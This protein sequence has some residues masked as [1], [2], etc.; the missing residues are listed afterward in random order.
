MQARV[1]DPARR[2]YRWQA[3]PVQALAFAVADGRHVDGDDHRPVAR[4]AGAL[5]QAAD[6]LAIAPRIQLE[7]MRHASRSR[8]LLDRVSAG[9]GED[10]SGAR[11][12]GAASDGDVAL[13]VREAVEA[14]R[15]HEHREGERL[16][17]ELGR[18]V[19]VGVAGEHALAQPPVPE[20][21]AI[22][23]ERDPVVGG[24]VDVGPDHQ[25]N[26]AARGPAVALD[27]DRRLAAAELELDR[28]H[29]SRQP[30]CDWSRLEQ[31]GRDLDARLPVARA[32]VLVD[33]DLH[34]ILPGVTGDSAR[35]RARPLAGHLLDVPRGPA[36]RRRGDTVVE[37]R[38]R[39]CFR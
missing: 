27:A 32:D 7:P 11:V 38:T 36:R 16:A 3:E 5:D 39:T 37:P 8:D 18:Q 26:R 30:S 14:G 33:R 28:G 24:A 17:L 23:G 2:Q 12:L 10:E 15:G 13:P 1:G 4:A 31:A 35:G 19:V 22:L 9:A 25:R 20:R 6:Q 21:V 29:L 34:R